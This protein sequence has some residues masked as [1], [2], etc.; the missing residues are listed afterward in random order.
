MPTEMP[1]LEMPKCPSLL[2]EM[3]CVCADPVRVLGCDDCTDDMLC[4]DH[5]LYMM[6]A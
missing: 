6:P 5:V 1:P 3:P 4:T 2:P